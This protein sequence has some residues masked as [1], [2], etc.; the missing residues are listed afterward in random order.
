MTSGGVGSVNELLRTNLPCGLYSALT[1]VRVSFAITAFDLPQSRTSRYVYPN[2]LVERELADVSSTSPGPWNGV[3]AREKVRMTIFDGATYEEGNPQ[4]CRLG[5]SNLR[6]LTSSVV[7]GA[8][9]KVPVELWGV[10]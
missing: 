8:V 6:V 2:R 5:A 9:V 10:T 4:G 7:P 3:N 1:L